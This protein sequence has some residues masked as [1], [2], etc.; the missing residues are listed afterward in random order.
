MTSMDFIPPDTRETPPAEL[1]RQREA[2]DC[3]I[4]VCAMIAGLP[5][6]VA[7]EDFPQYDGS[8]GLGTV[9][10]ETYLSRLGYFWKRTYVPLYEGGP[11]PPE[12]FAPIH[13]AF[14]GQ[15]SGNGHIVVM[16]EDGTVLDPLSDKPKR[17]ADWE[18]TTCVI[19]F[20]RW[21]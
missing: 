17:L 21:P 12:P 16:L 5:Y 4:A 13:V 3:G 8:R 11:W 15:P 20:L 9:E 18:V 1:I 14:V 2:N 19:G 7:R 10:V 6:E